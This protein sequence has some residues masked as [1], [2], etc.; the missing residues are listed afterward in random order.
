MIARYTT[1]Q[2][3]MD[4]GCYTAATWRELAASAAAVWGKP[5][6][7]EIRWRPVDGEG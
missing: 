2:G 4:S 7:V 5:S 3:R 6:D 1:L